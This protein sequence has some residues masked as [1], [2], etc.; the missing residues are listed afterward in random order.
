[1]VESMKGLIRLH[2]FLL[3][4]AVVGSPADRAFSDSPGIQRLRELGGTV[5]EEGV[6][7]VELKLDG[8][9]MTE[10]DIQW[11]PLT[12]DEEQS[13]LIKKLKL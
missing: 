11:Q 5:K 7:V 10:V 12:D 8:T 13:L 9:D 3:L 4:L 2:S 6:A 1:M